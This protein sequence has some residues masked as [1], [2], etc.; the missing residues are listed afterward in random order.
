M[1]RG[2]GMLKQ[3]RIALAEPSLL[4]SFFLAFFSIFFLIPGAF[5][6]DGRYDASLNGA[7]V[8]TTTATG[9]SVVQGA[10]VGANIFGTF[11]YKFRPK[12]S[13]VFNFGRTRDS[14]TYQAIG[15]N[16][17]VLNSISEVT[18]AYVFSPFP[19][20]KF[21]PFVLAGGGALVFSP[22]STWVFFPNLPNNVPNR[23]ETS[24]GATSQTE[25][26]FLYGLGVDYKLPWF[27]KVSLRLQYRGF[28]YKA[29]DFHIDQ[30]GGSQVN[31][32]TGGKQHMA[33]PTVGFVYTF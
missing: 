2:Y 11:R 27:T 23:V 16:F 31:F 18:G 29:P 17:H 9:N 3:A 30:N 12:H 24:L 1:K 26:A 7:A 6:Q 21:K 19:E 13:L 20:A 33:E 22:S 8:F 32:F 5:G 25:V 10:T 28:L 4:A 14:Q 15:N